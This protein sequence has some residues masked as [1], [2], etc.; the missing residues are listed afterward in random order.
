MIKKNIVFVKNNKRIFTVKRTNKVIQIHLIAGKNGS[1]LFRRDRHSPVV[2]L[3]QCCICAR[4]GIRRE[5][6]ALHAMETCSTIDEAA[7]LIE[8]CILPLSWFKS[9]C[10]AGRSV[11]YVEVHL[12]NSRRA[13]IGYG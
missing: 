9:L 10:V 12:K 11:G 3:T 8:K 4:V 6:H 1:K 7:Y 2:R 5:D 13:S